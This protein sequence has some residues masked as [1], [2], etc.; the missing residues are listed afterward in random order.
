MTILTF[1]DFSW[2][3]GKFVHF[4]YD[5]FSFICKKLPCL[6]S[7]YHVVEQKNEK[8][9]MQIQMVTSRYWNP[10]FGM[11]LPSNLSSLRNGTIIYSVCLGIEQFAFKKKSA[12][13]AE[14][15]PKKEAN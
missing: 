12:N 14:F 10:S 9:I 7:I 11:F 2:A 15:R 8:T 4:N 5:F 6:F 3:L 1:E 13:F